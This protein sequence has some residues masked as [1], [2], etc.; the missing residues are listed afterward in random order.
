MKHVFI[1]GCM[2]FALGTQAQTTLY[3]DN[4]LSAGNNGKTWATAIKELHVALDSAH[5]NPNIT[6]IYVAKGT[7]KPKNFVYAMASGTKIGTQATHSDTLF[8][9]FHV[10]VGLE[11]YGGYPNGG[12]TRDIVANPTIL[13]G[14]LGTKKAYHVVFLDSPTYWAASNDTT[15]IDG[16]TIQNGDNSAT[17]VSATYYYNYATYGGT[18]YYNIGYNGGGI[19]AYTTTYKIANCTIQNNAAKGSGNGIYAQ[20][21][22]S[23][24]QNNI[25][26][27][28]TSTTSTGGG[29]FVQYGSC[30]ID[31][32]RI[33]SNT[34]STG[35]GLQLNQGGNYS[36]Y[37][38]IVSNNSA[39]G[40]YGGGIYL[41]ANT[42]TTVK[43]NV[44][45][46]NSS[47]NMGGGV[48]VGTATMVKFFNNLV[49]NNTATN[50]GGGYYSNNS[51]DS[52]VNCTIFRN[53][54]GSVGAGGFYK[55]SGGISN[56]INTIFWGNYRTGATTTTANADITNANSN[57]LNVSYSL[58]QLSNA[59]QYN[60]SNFPINLIT[61]Q[62]NNKYAKSPNFIDSTNLAGA[63]GQ[64]FTADDG[65][66][67][68]T[69]SPCI[70]SGLNS[71]IAA[72]PVDL[73]YA[74]RTYNSTV[75]MGAY[76]GIPCGILPVISLTADTLYLSANGKAIL[77]SISI[78]SGYTHPLNFALVKFTP[79]TLN[80]L[81][82]GI[83]NPVELLV[84]SKY[85][86]DSAIDTIIVQIEDT[87][88][89]IQHLR[90]SMTTT[91]SL[92]EKATSNGWT[93]YGAPASCDTFPIAI[94][95][96]GNSFTA[97]SIVTV[98]D[99]HN[100]YSSNGTNQE[101]ASFLIGRYWN[102][103]VISGI[104]DFT[105]NPV[106]VRFLFTSADTSAP[107]ISRD[108]A[109]SAL[110][111]ANASTFAVKNTSLEWFKSTGV[112]YDAAWI[113]GIVGN[114]FPVNMVKLA[115]TY[116]SANGYSYVDLEGITSFS[117]G[118]GG[119]SYGAANGGSANGLPITWLSI[120]AQSTSEGNLI[121]WS[122]ASEQRSDYFVVEYSEDGVNFV[123][124]H[125]PI[126]AQG[127]SA[128]TTDYQYLHKI[129]ANDLYYRIFQKDINDNADYS[130]IVKVHTSNETSDAAISFYP[131]PIVDNLYVQSKSIDEQPI[132]FSVYN[133]LGEKLYEANTL[134]GGSQAPHII[135]VSSWQKG[136]YLIQYLDSSALHTIK[137][138]KQ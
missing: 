62:S 36:V 41:A 67:L 50:N 63:D 45:T 76:E 111:T 27:N 126:K 107:R 26:Q 92:V 31:S 28:N 103:E 127:N 14:T 30:N 40:S 110:K 116:G 94:F 100:H 96:N 23:F 89:A 38:N 58:L 9:T 121:K 86:L 52:I 135:D 46:N 54:G 22:R 5:K 19:F 3:V 64:Y 87:I 1:V 43:Y 88:P 83:N 125:G 120:T 71:V 65:L 115:G 35:G 136:I 90:T 25:I 105:A 91:D 21:A 119:F 132:S 53:I 113:S 133:T 51:S 11:L 42:T 49:A 10:R 47:S 15:I 138:M 37:K 79:S 69:P 13:D 118:T 55:T 29:V 48:A 80:C 99:R 128:A 84:K 117:G 134:I 60:G 114:K 93:Y 109:Y 66:R 32:N 20:Y 24:I 57:T 44:I 101:H 137:V 16:F 72:Y 123:S 61:N 2:F 130:K 112:P 73:I 95:K 56:I 78:P 129:N 102:A 4:T 97:K 82:I 8:K 106:K 122:T 17:T 34:A 70:D 33:L 85:C 18:P 131:N 75:D 77:D 12:G 98:A 7:Y 74:Q 39:S 81:N 124:T 6:K 59:S 68:K 104:N 108:S